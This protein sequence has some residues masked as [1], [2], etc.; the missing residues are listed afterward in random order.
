MKIQHHLTTIILTPKK[1]NVYSSYRNAYLMC[2]SEG[3]K[4]GWK[5]LIFYKHAIPL[6]LES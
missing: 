4:C 5:R 6:G 3:V 1:S 2:D